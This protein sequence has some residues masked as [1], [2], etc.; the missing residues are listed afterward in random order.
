MPMQAGGSLVNASLRATL[1]LAFA[2]LSLL[3]PLVGLYGSLSYLTPERTT[4]LGIRIALGA[5]RDQLLQMMLL[6]SL[7][8]ALLG[9]GIGLMMKVVATR[10]FQSILFGTRPLDPL[11]LSG[12]IAMLSGVA[13]LACLAPHGALLG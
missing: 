3:L 12:V 1:V 2:I 9:L 4:E 13:A 5:R 10:I 6:D 11:V 7:R 8:P